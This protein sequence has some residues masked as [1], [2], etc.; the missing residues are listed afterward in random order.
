MK[1]S[2]DIDANKILGTVLEMRDLRLNSTSTQ[3]KSEFPWRVEVVDIARGWA[4]AIEH[5]R[6]LEPVV[7]I[8]VPI[9]QRK[10]GRPFE[11]EIV[12][13]PCNDRCRPT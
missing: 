6:A 12:G 9:F 11:L 13:V 4:E 7:K 10:P 1:I 5:L 3:R 2:T 8:F